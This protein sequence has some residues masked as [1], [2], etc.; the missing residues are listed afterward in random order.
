MKKLSPYPATVEIV[1][2][3][4]TWMSAGRCAKRRKTAEN[5]GVLVTS[6]L[7][8]FWP[9]GGSRSVNHCNS[10]SNTPRK[11]DDQKCRAPTPVQGYISPYP[12]AQE[13]AQWNREAIDSHRG[14]SAFA[15]KVISDDGDGCRRAARLADPDADPREHQLREVTRESRDRRGERPERRADGDDGDA[16]FPLGHSGD[17]NAQQRIQHPERQAAQQAHLR[18]GDVQ[19]SFYRLHEDLDDDPIDEAEGGDEGE[20]KQDPRGVDPI[21]RPWQRGAGG[22]RHPP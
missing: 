5:G 1:A 21:F 9:R 16:A 8:S 2:P 12:A 18:I 3:R 4:T 14:R 13:G 11:A 19:L 15:G 17:G 20:E 6:M 22:A 10:A 7:G